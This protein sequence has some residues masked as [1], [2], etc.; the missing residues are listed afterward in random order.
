MNT[1]H[2][3]FLNT[4]QVEIPDAMPSLDIYREVRAKYKAW[5]VRRGYDVPVMEGKDSNLRFGKKQ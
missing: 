3:R 5:K 1:N 4:K 2:G